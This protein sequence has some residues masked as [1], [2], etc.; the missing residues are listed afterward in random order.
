[1][2]TSSDTIESAAKGATKAVIE[3]SGAA[4]TSLV[5]KFQTR[6]LAFIQNQKIISDISNISENEEFILFKKYIDNKSSHTLFKLGIYL[7]KLEHDRD[8]YE[9]L[10]QKI[11][12]RHKSAGI[13]I[14]YI[15]QNKLFLKLH[16]SLAERFTQDLV[17]RELNSIFADIDKYILFI[18]RNDIESQKIQ[19]AL[20]KVY[21]H[22]PDTFMISSWMKEAVKVCKKIQGKL[23]SQLK[24][25]YMCQFYAE[26]DKQMYIFV[27]VNS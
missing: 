24:S 10:K 8:S 23:Y 9:N 26:D 25:N 16:A 19:E 7:R 4:I 5:Q 6:E 11:I 13:H 27:K 14:A 12:K 20:S 1:M 15:A 3:W 22:S 18:S 17:R 2:V 21:A